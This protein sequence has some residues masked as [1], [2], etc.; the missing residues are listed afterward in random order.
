MEISCLLNS[1][2]VHPFSCRRSM[3]KTSYKSNFISCN[4]SE[5][6]RGSSNY[7]D[8]LSLKSKDVDLQDIKKAYKSLVRRYH[9]DLVPASRKEESTKRFVELQKAY[10]TLSDP[11]LRENYDIKSGYSSRCETISISSQNRRTSLNKD[12]WEDQL[13]G[14]QS[15]S[16]NK[17]GKKSRAFMSD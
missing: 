6:P 14:L 17:R 2:Q 3:Q 4:I 16:N 8:V 12:I 11:I 10:E 1:K 7:Y 13:S 9:P 15:R 5:S